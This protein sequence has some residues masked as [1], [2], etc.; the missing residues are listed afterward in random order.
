MATVDE[1]WTTIVNVAAKDGSIRPIILKAG[2][3][4]N[5]AAAV[6]LYD[7]WLVDFA[8]VS[9]GAVKSWSHSHGFHDDAFALPTNNGAERGEYAIIVTNIAGDATKTAVINLPFP[10]DTAGVVYLNDNV[11]R[12]T[13]DTDSANLAA[14][15]DNFQTGAYQISD[16]EHSAGNIVRGKR[17][18]T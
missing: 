17:A 18:G 4:A 1:G 11:G 12:N 10:V 14:Y 5:E 2:V 9:A 15:L 6:A 3:L 13:V 8:V 7:A 16:G